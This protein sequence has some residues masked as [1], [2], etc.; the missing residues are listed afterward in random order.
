MVVQG[1]NLEYSICLAG[2]DAEDVEY[3]ASISFP[4]SD[5]RGCVV[6]CTVWI[7]VISGQ[8]LQKSSEGALTP[9]KQT[10]IG[11]GRGG[12]GRGGGGD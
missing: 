10:I 4:A 8:S 5:S 9:H 6:M 2:I 11:G 3:S 7:P 1:Q 12:G